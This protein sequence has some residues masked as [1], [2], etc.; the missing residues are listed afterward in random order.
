MKQSPRIQQR[1]R[2]RNIKETLHHV[3]YLCGTLLDSRATVGLCLVLMII[4]QEEL[5]DTCHISKLFFPK[6]KFHILIK[7]THMG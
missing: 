7:R 4:Q 5:L 1:L 2:L 6:R 3:R